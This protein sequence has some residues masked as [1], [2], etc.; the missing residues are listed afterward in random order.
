MDLAVKVKAEVDSR[1]QLI[2][3]LVEELK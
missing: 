2:T 1:N 3:E